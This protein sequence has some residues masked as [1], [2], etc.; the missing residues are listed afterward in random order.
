[1][2]NTK[3]KTFSLLKRRGIDVEKIRWKI[4]FN[5]EGRVFDISFDLK[6]PEFQK[7]VAFLDTCGGYFEGGEFKYWLFPNKKVIGRRAYTW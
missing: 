7:L 4:T 2:E 6:N 3:A 1:M 5:R